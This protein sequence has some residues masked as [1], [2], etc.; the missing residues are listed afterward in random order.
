ML[1]ECTST[2]SIPSVSVPAI[3]VL[4]VRNVLAVLAPTVMTLLPAMLLG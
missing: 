4:L 2:L 1:L 3:F